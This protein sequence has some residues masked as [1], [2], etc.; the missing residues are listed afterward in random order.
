M[1][2]PGSP[3]RDGSHLEPP[4]THK[5]PHDPSPAPKPMGKPPH[6]PR[7]PPED[8]PRPVAV[9]I[10]ASA[11][12]TR[13]SSMAVSVPG[14]VPLPRGRAAPG[15]PP[16]PG[17]PSPAFLRWL[18]Q[19]GQTPG[20]RGGQGPSRVTTGPKNS[21]EPSNPR[22]E[23]PRLRAPA[24]ARRGETEAQRCD[25]EALVVLSPPPPSSAWAPRVPRAHL[26]T[27]SH[28]GLAR[29]WPCPVGREAAG[30]IT[31]KTHPKPKAKGFLFAK[32]CGCLSCAGKDF[33]LPP[34]GA[35]AS[36]SD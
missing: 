30:A 34:E 16:E 1:A 12:S 9:P 11:S 6:S 19:H 33:P 25:W 18:H 7:V 31:P 23:A 2:V 36:P 24:W 15:A 21:R 17:P 29:G 8:S 13:G 4:Q 14:C 3:Q 5:Q 35:V 20:G 27:Q 10:A 22:H 32:G 28:T 26:S